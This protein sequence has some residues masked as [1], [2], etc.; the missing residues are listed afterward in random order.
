MKKVLGI[1]I[2]LSNLL[3]AS[4]Y[5]DAEKGLNEMFMGGDFKCDVKGCESQKE[6]LIN[7]EKSTSKLSKV[8]LE[9]FNGELK[10]S[11]DKSNAT[12]VDKR[13][14]VNESF[15]KLVSHSKT[16]ELIDIE[17]INKQTNKK[18]TVGKISLSFDNEMN[19]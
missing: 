17:V 6:M 11:F 4:P 13:T 5:T 18:S 2:V 12:G 14:A 19:F 1:S 9:F 7:D 16:L 8:K 15:S 10:Y 3:L